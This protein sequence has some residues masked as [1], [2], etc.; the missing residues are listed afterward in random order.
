M[1]MIDE[2]VNSHDKQVRNVWIKYK[3]GHATNS[4]RVERDVKTIFK[5]LSP[6]ETTLPSML[7]RARP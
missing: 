5:L 4:I 6:E 3:I 7:E 1:G 2:I